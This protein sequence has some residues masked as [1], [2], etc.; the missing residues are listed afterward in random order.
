MLSSGS[1]RQCSTNTLSPSIIKMTKD[2][3][4]KEHNHVRLN[5]HSSSTSARS[6]VTSQTSFANT[7][8][9]VRKALLSRNHISSRSHIHYLE[10]N[11]AVGPSSQK[12]W[13]VV[14][15]H[16]TTH[17]THS[18]SPSSNTEQ[19]RHC[20]HNGTILSKKLRQYS[21]TQSVH[22][23]QRAKRHWFKNLRIP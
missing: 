19:W 5:N 2:K 22:V 12:P 10:S 20:V 15:T 23:T 9:L 7:I 17:E 16:P 18:G 11:K 6:S 1:R 3:T 8:I 14:L 21:D 13:S 4:S